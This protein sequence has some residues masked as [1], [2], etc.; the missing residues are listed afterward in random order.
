MSSGGARSSPTPGSAS[1]SEGW[2][3]VSYRLRKLCPLPGTPGERRVA[4]LAL[5]AGALGRQRVELRLPEI[6]E[7]ADPGIDRLEPGGIHR[8][9]PPLCFS[10]D[11]CK[12][13]LAQHLEMLRHRSL[14]D[15]ELGADRLDHRA[16]RHLPRT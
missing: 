4:P 6:P 8:I 3:A 11:F 7:A 13:A 9:E 15:A 14:C 10:A 16:G 2:A 5:A 12:A 1:R